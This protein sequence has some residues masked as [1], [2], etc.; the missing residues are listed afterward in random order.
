MYAFRFCPDC[1]TELPA[2]ADERLLAQ[3]CPACKAIHW[4]NAKPCAG[5]LIVRDGQ[6]LLGRRAVAPA[7][8]A[9]DIPGG[10]LEPWEVPAEAA[11]REVREETGLEVRVATLLSVVV[12]TYAGRDYTLNLY[13]VA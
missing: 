1:G 3:T 4:R 5:A 7:R 10:F 8:G 12:D 2:A 6:V 13:Y 11:I 9:W